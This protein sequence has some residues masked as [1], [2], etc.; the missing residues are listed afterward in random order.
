MLCELLRRIDLLVLSWTDIDHQFALRRSQASTVAPATFFAL[1]RDEAGGHARKRQQFRAPDLRRRLAQDHGIVIVEPPE[2][3]VDAYREAIERDA[4]IEIPG[5]GLS[6]PVPEVILW[7]LV[8]DWERSGRTD[9]EDELPPDRIDLGEAVIDL[10]NFPSSDL[11]RCMLVAGPGSRK[12][13]VAH[14]D[15]RETRNRRDPAGPSAARL[16]RRKWGDGRRLSE[17]PSQPRLRRA[18]RLATDGRAGPGC[19]AARWPGR[20]AGPCPGP[21]ARAA[22]HIFRPATRTCPGC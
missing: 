4:R 14:G 7:P 8:R 20:S 21:A 16:A 5:T 17:R 9:F 18:H 13:G 1:L 11:H 19:A 6:G 15:C 22:A 2:W 12:V 3:G 10:Q